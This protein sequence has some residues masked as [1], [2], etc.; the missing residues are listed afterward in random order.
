MA[1][2][3]KHKDKADK[4][5]ILSVHDSQA[6]TFEQIDSKTKEF[7]KQFWGGHAFP[8]PIFID[9]NGETVASW[10]ITSFPTV[11]IVDPEGKF[12]RGDLKSVARK[13]AS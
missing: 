10:G 5:V 8:F 6:Q 4:F 2:Q 13:L 3:E 11:V 1:F 7:E 9:G 12:F